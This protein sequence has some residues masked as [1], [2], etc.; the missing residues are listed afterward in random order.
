VLDQSVLLEILVFALLR[1]GLIGRVEFGFVVNHVVESELTKVKLFGLNELPFEGFNVANQTY[2]LPLIEI[3]R[4]IDPYSFG[5]VVYEVNLVGHHVQPVSLGD[6]SIHARVHLLPLPLQFKFKVFQGLQQFQLM[7]DHAYV[8]DVVDNLFALFEG[9]EVNF[10]RALYPFEKEMRRKLFLVSH[11][12]ELLPVLKIVGNQ[13]AIVALAHK[14][15]PGFHLIAVVEV[16][17]VEG[18]VCKD[19]EFVTQPLVGPFVQPFV[20]LAVRHECSLEPAVQGPIV[21]LDIVVES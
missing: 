20:F 6:E 7:S 4:F 5:S 8:W 13:L 15:L 21:E 1:R 10:S 9:V 11:Q 19:R 17:V 14:D 3:P 18:R 12:V 16:H 2:P